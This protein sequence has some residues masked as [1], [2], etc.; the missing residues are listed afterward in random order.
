MKREPVK[1][2]SKMR[3][4]SAI[5]LILATAMVA[6]AVFAQTDPKVFVAPNKGQSADQQSKDTAECKQTATAQAPPSQA[7][8]GAGTHARGTVGGAA[9]GAAA[10]AAIGAIAG[11]AGKGAAAGAAVGGVAGRRGSKRG[12]QE[13]QAGAQSDWARA[14]AACMESRGYTVK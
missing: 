9:R 13:A 2:E 11:D 14:F 7:P 1:E 8:T 3:Y 10:G 12:Q 6:S 4:A 5:G